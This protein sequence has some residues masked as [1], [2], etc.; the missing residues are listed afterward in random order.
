M[1]VPDDPPKLDYEPW[2]QPRKLPRALKV[3]IWVAL[4]V[5]AMGV[6]PVIAFL[7]Y[8]VS[9][10]AHGSAVGNAISSGL[11]C[12]PIAAFSVLGFFVLLSRVGERDQR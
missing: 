9:D 8:S 10:G 6:I 4:L 12:I 1:P 11:C 5:H 7:L 3:T 2:P